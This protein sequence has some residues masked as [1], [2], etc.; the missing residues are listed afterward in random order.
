MGSGSQAKLR[1]PSGLP[2][3]S[4]QEESGKYLRTGSICH[5]SRWPYGA[6]T[7]PALLG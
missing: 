5:W 3:D 2:Q 6:A 1:L 4:E 7:P